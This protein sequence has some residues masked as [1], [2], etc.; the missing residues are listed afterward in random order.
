MP[1]TLPT[2]PKRVHRTAACCAAFAA[3]LACAVPATAV[4]LPPDFVVE[5]VPFV[6]DVPT[7]IAFLPDGRLLV[8]EK[9]GILYVVDGATRHP[10]WV[11][12]EEVLNAGDRGFLSVAV[13][14]HFD[15]NRYL[16]FLVAVDP[17]S[18]G[19]E[20]NN[21]DDTFAR[22][23][24]YQVSATNPNL[25]DE[26]TRAAL[27][28][29]TW[30]QGFASGSESHTI[31]DLAWGRDGT[32]LVSAGDGAHFDT[33]DP[34]GYDPGLFEP[35]RTDPLEDVGAFRSQML[36]SKDGKVLRI[37]PATGLGLPSNPYWNGDPASSHKSRRCFG[38][39]QH[40]NASV[41]P[42]R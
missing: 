20:L 30:R 41:A 31:G 38:L 13:D 39:P 4:T 16:Y 9:G 21:Y 24:R 27:L 18:D 25:V 40:D 28:G 11:H 17:D 12:E 8:A 36:D 1:S 15:Q 23:L 35:D 3:V 14:P 26:S 33:M 32:L 22:L 10:M 34:G 6:F 2:L 5:T 7:D 19:V 42:G 29:A 37:D